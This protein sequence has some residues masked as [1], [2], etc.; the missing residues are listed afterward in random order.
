[1]IA[2]AL[3]T[4]L[5]CQTGLVDPAAD[6][7]SVSAAQAGLRLTYMCGTRF[8]IRTT[9]SDTVRVRWDVYRQ[10]DTGS[11]LVPGVQSPATQRDVFFE[12]TARGTTRIFLGTQRIDT[13]ANGGSVCNTPIS[14]HL[15]YPNDSAY[16]VID[17]TGGVRV[18]YFRRIAT[19]VLQES[20]TD[21]QVSA[22]LAQYEAQILSG[23]PV[24]RV[25]I[26]QLP[27]LGPSASAMWQRVNTMLADPRVV[28]IEPASTTGYFL[29]KSGWRFP[30]DAARARTGNAP[31]S[32]EGVAQSAWYGVANNENW[33]MKAI[34]A[35]ASW[36]CENG[37]YGPSSQLPSVAV[38]EAFQPQDSDLQA[39]L[40]L[41][42]TVTI[43]DSIPG[44]DQTPLDNIGYRIHSRG[45]AGL[46]SA[47]GDNGAGS[48]GVMWRTKLHTATLITPTGRT[49]LPSAFHEKVVPQLVRSGV[50]VINISV[51][52]ESPTEW[53]EPEIQLRYWRRTLVRHPNTL[54]V[55]A[56]GQG[57]TGAEFVTLPPMSALSSR[58][59]SATSLVGNVL[60]HFS[61]LKKE[62][63]RNLLIVGGA[64]PSFASGG[65]TPMRWEPGHW[66]R[67]STG[68]GMDVV[69][70]AQ[71][72]F[73]I[74]GVLGDQAV[75]FA[76]GTSFAAPLVS[77]AAAAALA[78]DPS[79]TAVQLRDFIVESSRDPVVDERTGSSVTKAAVYDGV[80]MLNVFNL[81]RRVAER[82][83]SLPICG[84][85]V[86]AD[87]GRNVIRIIRPAGTIE[88]RIHPS[89]SA[90]GL[91]LAYDALSVAPGGRRIAASY[92]PNL[93]SDATAFDYQ[94][95]TGG[96]TRGP[97]KTGINQ[98]YYVD[99]DTL[100]L[101]TNSHASFQ[102]RPWTVERRGRV[103]STTPILDHLR[104]RWANL[105]V[106]PDPTGRFAFARAR[107]EDFTL[108]CSGGGAGSVQAILTL[109]TPTVRTLRVT[110]WSAAC[111]TGPVSDLEGDF[112]WAQN[113]ESGWQL[114]PETAYSPTNAP[115]KTLM[116]RW[117]RDSTG[118]SAT[119]SSPTL[120]AWLVLNA[121][122]SFDGSIISTFE[123]NDASATCRMRRVA[124]SDPSQQISETVLPD[125][126]NRQ[127]EQLRIASS[128]LS[129]VPSM[130]IH[131]RPVVRTP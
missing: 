127:R 124:F 130:S 85:P 60:Y 65:V 67:T 44:N 33:A 99:G 53:R 48:A 105:V 107:W 30:D 84:Q 89:D 47:E 64:K 82:S 98:Q 66:V 8:R 126:N 70:P 51:H 81:L 108:E 117:S 111:Q 83:S 75:D 125:C 86:V 29:N 123:V 59:P 23:L 131:N 92:R 15:G 45:V 41:G 32:A 68:G 114:D 17:S 7:V 36:A 50:R 122:T 19:V 34:G 110:T 37:L 72:V 78:L 12:T 113:G 77:G 18:T 21:V 2:L 73:T 25:Y 76:T 94:L 62:G 116:Q 40:A 57:L 39:S 13:K 74:Y 90:L 106:S 1:M 79:L 88:L 93:D 104:T 96:W 61:R 10:N 121:R 55:L 128:S 120:I 28:T 20:L 52:P 3:T 102:S 101:R 100:F 97:A 91:P 95:G 129:P 87:A 42:S 43:N 71:N 119:G 103:N 118:W 54:F 11:V 35:N 46:I 22:F 49:L 4:L 5:A 109:G 58:G 115:G 6:A 14:D 27:D 24:T 38:V 9:R 56:A 31:P 16:K 80:Y 63:F 26:I 69:A 112:A